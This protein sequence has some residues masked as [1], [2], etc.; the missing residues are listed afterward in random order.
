MLNDSYSDKLP[1]LVQFTQHTIDRA[2]AVY[3]GYRQGGTGHNPNHRVLAAWA[4]VMLDIAD[5][6]AYLT[7]ATNFHEDAY[8][9]DGINGALWGQ[10]SYESAYWNY[11]MGLGGNR[12]NKD[13][14]DYIDGGDASYG[15]GEYQIITS[16]SLK[17]Q[18]LVY[19]LFPELQACIPSDRLVTH[20]AWT[21]PD[22]AAPYDGTN[23]NY[24]VTFGPD[25]LGGYIVGSGRFTE[26]DGDNKDGGQ[27][28]STFVENMWNAYW[29]RRQLRTTTLRA[30]KV[31]GP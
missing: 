29:N 12:S 31:T 9:Y 18:A 22:P 30:G 15:G 16:Q 2:Y 1:V 28:K 26:H 11:I 10:D 17:G 3:L 14:Y 20:G 13:P 6:K 25:G 7:T 27:Y 4:A 8:L 23:E 21:L 24:G 5:I 19:R